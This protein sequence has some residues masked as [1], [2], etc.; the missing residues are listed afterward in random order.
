[1]EPAVMTV[2]LTVLSGVVV[3]VLG[4]LLLKLVIEP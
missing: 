1:M 3:F 4:Q 2:F